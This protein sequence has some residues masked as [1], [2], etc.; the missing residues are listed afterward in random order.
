M[1][2]ISE[3]HNLKFKR[4]FC[5]KDFR[6]KKSTKKTFRFS[7]VKA[8]LHSHP[9]FL[10]GV[11]PKAGFILLIWCENLIH[12]LRWPPRLSQDLAG[13][14]EFPNAPHETCPLL[15]VP[16]FFGGPKWR[17]K[18]PKPNQKWKPSW[19]CPRNTCHGGEVTFCLG[20]FSTCW[21]DSLAK[22][23]MKIK[24]TFKWV[25]WKKVDSEKRLSIFESKPFRRK[26][27]R[28]LYN[29]TWLNNSPKCPISRT[30]HQC[31]V[32]SFLSFGSPRVDGF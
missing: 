25:C 26:K 9:F 10:G 5:K 27:L 11:T 22:M 6:K 14:P 1:V 20:V 16:G 2:H 13:T 7:I 4:L 32:V 29:F 8:S 31:L 28:E 12:L 3:I 24:E 30:L 17:P 23:G 19:R 18:K 21:H 15:A